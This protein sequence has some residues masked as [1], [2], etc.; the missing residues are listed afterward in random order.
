[1]GPSRASMVRRF[2]EERRRSLLPAGAVPDEWPSVTAK[3]PNITSPR[4]PSRQPIYYPWRFAVWC[5]M[6]VAMAMMQTR[7][8]GK[9]SDGVWPVD[10]LPLPTA[11]IKRAVPPYTSR[12]L[13][14]RP[15][16]VCRGMRV[17][18]FTP[19]VCASQL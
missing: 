12:M 5:V 13:P 9:Q 1:M 6:D 4:S 3:Q 18:N 11:V 17:M 8:P 14:N 10:D 16:C 19:R 2:T 7:T 15:Y